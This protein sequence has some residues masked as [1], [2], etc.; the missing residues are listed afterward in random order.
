MTMAMV[1][2]VP[3]YKSPARNGRYVQW[4]II[5]YLAVYTVSSIVSGLVMS[6]MANPGAPQALQALASVA[7]GLVSFLNMGVSVAMSIFLY[8]WIFQV[9][10]NLLALGVPGLRFSPGWSIGWFFVPVMNL[11][12]PWQVMKETVQASQSLPA[13]ASPEDWKTAPY[14]PLVH[15]WWWLPLGLS[16]I[17]GGAA[18]AMMTVLVA[19]WVIKGGSPQAVMDGMRNYYWFMIVPGVAVMITGQ[20]LWIFLIR[21]VVRLQEQKYLAMAAP[22]TAL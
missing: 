9:R 17:V 8:L 7:N 20:V 15:Y 6:I 13:G 5:A 21:Q 4:L 3:V 19:G 2:P 1:P 18:L 22:P 14:S 12:R 10:R 16:V 11:F